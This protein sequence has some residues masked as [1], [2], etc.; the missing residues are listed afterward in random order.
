MSKNLHS[1]VDLIET[2]FIFL[3]IFLTLSQQHDSLK[4]SEGVMNKRQENAKYV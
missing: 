1:Q 2:V 4:A 3:A